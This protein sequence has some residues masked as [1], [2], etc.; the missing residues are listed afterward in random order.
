MPAWV[1][2]WDW[3][4]LL[5][6]MLL[7][8]C[9]W[10]RA[11][12]RE[13]TLIRRQTEAFTL[14]NQ[15]SASLP[16]PPVCAHSTKA[17]A[18]ARARCAFCNGA[19]NDFA[20]VSYFGLSFSSPAA[21]EAS[22]MLRCLPAI[23]LPWHQ[24]TPT[25][26]N[27]LEMYGCTIVA[28]THHAWHLAMY[29]LTSTHGH[30]MFRLT[31]SWLQV[32]NVGH[33]HKVSTYKCFLQWLKFI[34]CL[35]RTYIDIPVAL[36]QTINHM[37]AAAKNTHMIFYLCTEHASTQVVLSHGSKLDLLYQQHSLSQDVLER[38]WWC[39]ELAAF[40]LHWAFEWDDR[41]LLVE[42]SPKQMYLTSHAFF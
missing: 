29:K 26:A 5:A 21:G 25:C 23:H 4:K 15:P 10:L 30:H 31:S 40:L 22:D 41:G 42:I 28:V 19:N 6:P 11:D 13:D 12:A 36:Q 8:P 32:R 37:V 38:P 2:T 16:H 17:V 9:S 7:H 14:S 34:S 18:S 24:C 3:A 33:H 1:T 27:T 35:A 39:Q 20:V